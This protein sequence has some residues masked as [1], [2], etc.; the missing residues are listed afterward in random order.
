MFVVHSASPQYSIPPKTVD[1]IAPSVWKTPTLNGPQN[2]HLS[3]LHIANGSE[4]HALLHGCGNN[5]HYCCGDYL[6]MGAVGMV[7]VAKSLPP[8]DPFVVN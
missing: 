7:L 5:H 6:W 4:G 1:R 2:P 3:N 8:K